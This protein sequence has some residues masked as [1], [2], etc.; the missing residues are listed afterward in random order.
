MQDPKNIPSSWKGGTQLKLNSKVKELFDRPT[1]CNLERFEKWASEITPCKKFEETYKFSR[2]NRFPIL[3]GTVPF[4]LLLSRY[5]LF[6]DGNIARL[7]N[8]PVI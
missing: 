7:G 3:L 5:K 1:Y 6:N 8:E 4:I 2:L